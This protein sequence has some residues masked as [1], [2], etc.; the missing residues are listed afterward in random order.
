M[1]KVQMIYIAF[2]AIGGLGLL[3]SLIFG[4]F[5]GDADFGHEF[6]ADGHD[7]G[8]AD[9]PKLFS[10]RVIF[11]FLMAFGIGGGA[12]FLSEKSIGNQIVVGILCGVST[13][14]ITYYIMKI[15]YSFQGNSNIDA[16][17]FI[18]KEATI[19]I[20]TTNNGSCQIKLDTGG[21][22]NLYIGKEKNSLRLRKYDI[23]KIIGQIGNVF[24]VEKVVEK[25]KV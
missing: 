12:M 14:A 24:I 17:N 20:E 25:E 11:A 23:V 18:G 4:E 3:S 15:L 1:E 7:A 19:T 22:D 2:L 9:S 5:H 16:A 21:G 6:S 8:D 10:L 13:G